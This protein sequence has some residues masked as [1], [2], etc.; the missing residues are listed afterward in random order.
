[1]LSSQEV[2]MSD[3][4]ARRY[5][6]LY[7][8][9]IVRYGALVAAQRFIA[10][11]GEAGPVNVVEI[12]VGSGVTS[13]EIVHDLIRRQVS[14]RYVGVDNMEEEPTG[15]INFRYSG[16]ELLVGDSTDPAIIAQVPDEIH[17]LYVDGDHK[18]EGV[19]ADVK[20]YGSRVASGFLMSMHD[21]ALTGAKQAMEELLQTLDWKLHFKTHEPT[22]PNDMT[23]GVAIVEKVE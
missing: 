7:E 21:I 16:M 5:T 19:A 3:T 4:E 23:P 9:M 14:Y 11:T 22:Q 1:M 6:P 20:H 2:G 17:F 18:Y 10:K 8:G 13:N 15:A 12:G